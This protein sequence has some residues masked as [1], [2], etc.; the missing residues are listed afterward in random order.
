MEK[1]KQLMSGKT[2]TLF[3]DERRQR[4]RWKHG[5]ETYYNEKNEMI[6]FDTLKEAVDWIRAEHPEMAYGFPDGM[7]FKLLGVDDGKT[8]D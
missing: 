6:E 4:F 3:Y 2:A 8:S 5:N 1:T 7:Q